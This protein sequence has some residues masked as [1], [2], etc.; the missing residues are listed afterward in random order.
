[1]NATLEQPEAE[2]QRV[3]ISELPIGECRP[4]PENDALYRPVDPEDPDI[5]A[6]AE[7]IAAQGMLEPVVVT[8]DGWIVSGH[9]RR[10]A[11]RLAGLEWI[12]C[13][14]L[15]VHRTD[16]IDAFVKLL[17]EFNRQREKNHAERLRECLIDV[18]PDE[19]YRELKEH[20]Q[21]KS[22]VDTQSMEL[23]PAKARPK[24]S[25]GK[26]PMLVAAIKAIEQLRDIWPLSLRKIHYELLN[27]PPLR[28]SSKPDSTYANNLRC[29]QDLSRLLIRARLD[30]H[31]PMDA[32]DDET[33]PVT[34]WQV[35]SECS[36]FIRR[37]LDGLLKNYARDLLQSQPNHLEI[38]GEK[39]TLG[40]TLR[41]IAGE[42][43]APLTL[44]GGYCSYPPRKAIAERFRKSGKS[45]LVLFILT[46]FDPDGFTIAESFA[47]SMKRD[48]KIADVCAIRV[49]L[50]LDQVLKHQLPPK[51]KAKEGSSQCAKFVAKFGD[52]V[53]ELE[54]L[55]PGAL[56]KI[57]RDA[58][59]STIDVAAFNHEIDEER[60]D[61]ARIDSLRRLIHET[62]RGVA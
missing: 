31:I 49:A 58:I 47:Q 28:H 20:R 10:E 42:F 51:I 5:I 30:G 18:N 57:L 44:G 34:V 26:K 14:V 4:S 39:K 16:D 45:K 55:S 7:S 48:F 25:K 19:A 21:A 29:Y 54:A 27:D 53:H 61:A 24:I 37:E 36:G 1:M 59:E 62:I 8:L 33:R 43:C 17:R 11:A 13:R 15:D 32:I 23:A 52:D 46:D 2:M 22:K 9:R 56:Q 3:A 41:P 6:L 50:T 35:D 12:P 38:L 40:T 60:K